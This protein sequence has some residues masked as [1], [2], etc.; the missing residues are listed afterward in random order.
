MIIEVFAQ[1]I[2]RVNHTI[3]IMEPL[4]N[5]AKTFDARLVV[6]VQI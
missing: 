6:N 5:L 4:H 1:G 2:D 3:Q